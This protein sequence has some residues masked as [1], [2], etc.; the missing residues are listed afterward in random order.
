M[1][2]SKTTRRGAGALAAAALALLSSRGVAA[3]PRCQ[4]NNSIVSCDVGGTTSAF[5]LSSA[6]LY[7]PKRR[8]WSASAV[9]KNCQPVQLSPAPCDWVG[10][11]TG[12]AGGGA[13]PAVSTRPAPEPAASAVPRP[14]REPAATAAPPRG[15]TLRV[16]AAAGEAVRAEPR[17]ATG[18]KKAHGA[19]YIPVRYPV[20]NPKG[21]ASRDCAW[22]PED[23]DTTRLAAAL[24]ARGFRPPANFRA[25]VAAIDVKGDSIVSLKAFD[26]DGHADEVAGWNPASTVKLFTTVGAIEFARA[27]GFTTSP[28]VRMHYPRGDVEFSLAQLVWAAIWKSDNIAHDRVAQVAGFDELHGEAGMLAR[29]G[30]RHSAVMKAYQT[31]DW[32]AEG[33]DRSL[34]TSPP[35]ALI[36]G[37]RS[38]EVP[39]RAGDAKPSCGGSACTTLQELSKMMCVVML[40]EQ[41][42]PARR[43]R[44][45]LGKD[46]AMLRYLRQALQAKRDK[47]PDGVWEALAA[48]FPGKG[49]GDD[50]TWPLWRKGGFSD[51]WISDN[52]FIR[53]RGSRRWLLSMSAYGGRHALDG[54]AKAMALVLRH[55]DL[56]DRRKATVKPTGKAKTR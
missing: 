13:P 46:A 42:P 3:L 49:S 54:A 20:P 39:G 17:G 33:H 36:A 22:R 48:Q 16:P 25:F 19:A 9:R 55:D 23:A 27:Q 2:W 43:L 38:V 30:L 12:T 26:Y 28:K 6:G 40:H 11:L 18:T 4:L 52:F 51:D 47:G 56:A 53:A 15:A 44:L 8:P 5:S 21:W 37:K 34:R 24:K 14:A 29:A 45:G 31:K 50:M 35:M 10:A 1:C 7:L 41:L 32:E